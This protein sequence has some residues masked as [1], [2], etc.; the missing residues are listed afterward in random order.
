MRIIIIF[1]TDLATISDIIIIIVII[2]IITVHVIVMWKSLLL[3]PQS[4]QRDV[5]KNSCRLKI[6]D[7]VTAVLHFMKRKSHSDV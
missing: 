4:E 6:M 2:I 1:A 5:R 3:W 7:K